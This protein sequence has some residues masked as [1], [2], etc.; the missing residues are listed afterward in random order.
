MSNSTPVHP[1]FVLLAVVGLSMSMPVPAVALEQS[2]VLVVYVDQTEGEGIYTHYQQYYTGVSKLELP[3]GTPTG[4]QISADDYL[5][6]FRQP[7]LTRIE[8]LS[9]Q[10]VDIKCIVTTKGM[11]LRIR[12]QGS[13]QVYSSLESEL[14]R[15]AAIS[16]PQ[17]M[18]NQWS[19]FMV[20]PLWGDD[21]DL[22]ANPYYAY[23]E[24]DMYGLPVRDGN[25]EVIRPANEGFNRNDMHL[26]SRLDGYSLSDVTASIDRA[27]SVSIRPENDYIVVDDDPYARDVSHAMFPPQRSSSCCGLRSE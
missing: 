5:S 24:S 20:P 1:A 12:N 13:S 23:Y 15:I 4:E 14:T 11:P 8:E 19:Y 22:S 17:Q 26:V 21:Y 9:A 16:T 10:G 2:E 3:V 25:G 27:Q 7:I 6:F 18:A